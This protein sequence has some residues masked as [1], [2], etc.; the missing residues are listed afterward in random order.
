MSWAP[1]RPRE[2][3]LTPPAAAPRL[4]HPAGFPAEHTISMTFRLPPGASREPFA[5][6]QLTDSR[7]QPKMGVTLDRE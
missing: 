3:R 5:L 6:W 2:L 4:I 1:R 7:F